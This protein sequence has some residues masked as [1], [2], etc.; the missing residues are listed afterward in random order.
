MVT[1]LRQHAGLEPSG[2][3]PTVSAATLEP[4]DPRELADAVSEFLGL[5]DVLNLELN[6]AE[7][8]AAISGKAETISRTA[9]YSVAEVARMLRDGGADREA[10]Q[11]ETGWLA[12][13]AGDIDD[14]RQHVAEE[15]AAR[16]R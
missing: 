7:P 4:V 12:V 16:G 1:R 14:V 5:L 10:W 11:V 13:L 9:A 2:G 6:G 8:S 15:E 3:A